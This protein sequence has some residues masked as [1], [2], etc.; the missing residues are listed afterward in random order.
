MSLLG[1]LKDPVRGLSRYSDS[2]AN[3]AIALASI[4]TLNFVLPRIMPGDPFH[5][6]YGDEALMNM[7]PEMEAEIIRRFSLDSTWSE[8]F[9]AYL[10]GLLRGDLG[11]SYFYGIQVT[12]VILTFLPW[13]I[14]LAGLALVI[15]TF[16]GVMIGIESGYRRGCAIDRML[17]AG[18]MFLSGFPHFFVG[19]LFLL[20]FSVTLG[21]MPLGGSATPYAGLT[22]LDYILDLL[23]HLTLPLVTLV[24]VQLAPT[25]LLSRN[26]MVTTLEEPF[27][28]TA[29][30]K[31]CT[32]AAIRYRHAGRNALLP[33]VTATGIHIPRMLTEIILVEIVFSYPGAGTLLNNA[34]SARDYPLIQGIL[35]MMTISVLTINLAIDFLYSRIDPRVRYAH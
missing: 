7:S 29:R 10:S 31:G 32:E 20:L 9:V 28:T 24:I 3:Y 16:L 34:L 18:L 13:T 25:Y 22:G 30:A 19:V 27:M 4:L 17:M 14:L 1:I 8:Q 6:I 26:T 5:A 15:S 33:V 21:I 23:H 12:D 35:L 2:I 11:Y